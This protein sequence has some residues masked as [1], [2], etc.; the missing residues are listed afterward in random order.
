MLPSPIVNFFFS[1]NNKLFPIKAK[2]GEN[3]LSVAH[4]NNIELEGA[5]EGSLACSTC[6]VILDN[7]LYNKL[8]TPSDREYDLLDQ[9]YDLTST[10]RLGCQLSVDKNYENKI[11]K[12]PKATR[13]MTV[14]GYVPK[15]H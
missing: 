3:I 15:P 2:P 4:K 10:S 1:K 14:D 9:A 13:N 8:K 12:I 5:C 6:H 7:E 11:L